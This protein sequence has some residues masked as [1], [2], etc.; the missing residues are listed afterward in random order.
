MLLKE[1]NSNTVSLSISHRL[2]IHEFNH[3]WTENIW[4][5]SPVNLKVKTGI[6]YALS[7]IY[8]AF[9]LNVKLFMVIL[10]PRG[11]VWAF[12]AMDLDS[13]TGWG[14][15]WTTLF[16]NG[17]SLLQYTSHILTYSILTY[18]VLLHDFFWLQ[19]FTF[20]LSNPLI[21]IQ[22]IRFFYIKGSCSECCTSLEFFHPSERLPHI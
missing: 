4:E 1:N 22:L 21:D 18:T 2:C 19:L 10:G 14:A 3:L 16:C 11:W 5:N 20:C 7:A 15:I 8:I 12:T 9:I 6:C 17:N 13:I